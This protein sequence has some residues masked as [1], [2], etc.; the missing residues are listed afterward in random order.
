MLVFLLQR[1]KGKAMIID[2]AKSFVFQRKP[3]G[4]V[5]LESNTML[6]ETK[7]LA[8]SFP[9]KAEMEEYDEIGILKLVNDSSNAIRISM[10][11]NIESILN[12]LFN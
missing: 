4:G 1:K 3:V 10:K 9:K 6:S 11:M 8:G 5:I 12:I 2:I 7:K